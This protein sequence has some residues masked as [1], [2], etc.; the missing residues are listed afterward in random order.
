MSDST[1]HSHSACPPLKSRQTGLSDMTQCDEAA[2]SARRR[3]TVRL[4]IIFC[5]ASLCCVPLVSVMLG[6]HLHARDFSYTPAPWVSAFPGRTILFEVVLVDADPKTR[7]MIMDWQILGEKSSDCS[8]SNL[9]ACTDIDIFFDDNLLSTSTT[10]SRTNN[11]PTEPIFHFNSTALAI[12]DPV[13]NTPTFRTELALFSP[14]NHQSSLIFYP[15]DRYSA[16]IFVFAQ[17]SNT[18]ELVGIE[19]HRTRGI[20]TGFK[21]VA[22]SGSDT[23]IPAGMIDVIIEVR[24]G[25]LVKS[26]SVVATISIW[27]ITVILLLVMITCVFF[28]FRQKSEVLCIPVGTLFA[29]TQLRASMPGAPEGFGDLLD[30]AR[31]FILSDPTEKPQVLSWELLFEA[32][33]RLD[34]RKSNGQLGKEPCAE[35]GDGNRLNMC[36]EGASKL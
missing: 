2:G 31:P 5:L 7:L 18:K 10:Q 4:W 33:P 34:H 1:Q 29:F 30:F 25:N 9:K 20:A 14:G 8:S 11:R 21:T 13:A 28:G 3:R 24:R 16:E 15:F 26:F 19:I 23:T 6:L 32:F 17:D 36:P 35:L 27:M 22:V 12:N